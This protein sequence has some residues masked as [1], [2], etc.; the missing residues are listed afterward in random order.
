MRKE[1][2]GGGGQREIRFSSGSS[3]VASLKAS[4]KTLNISIAPGL[5][6]DSRKICCG[7]LCELHSL[8]TLMFLD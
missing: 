4:G 6:K 7:A 5:P 8:M 1:G 2:W 3:N